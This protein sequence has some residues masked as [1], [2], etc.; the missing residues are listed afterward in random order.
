VAS[1]VAQDVYLSHVWNAIHT[2]RRTDET[3]GDQSEKSSYE[4]GT[5]LQTAVR[6]D[7]WS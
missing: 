2:D 6:R 7:R 5:V 3:T 1:V 4:D